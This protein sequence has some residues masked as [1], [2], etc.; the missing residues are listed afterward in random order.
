MHKYSSLF[1][2]T[3]TIIFIFH[4]FCLH[5]FFQ[6]A[7]PLLMEAFGPCLPNNRAG[8]DFIRFV[9]LHVEV[10]ALADADIQVVVDVGVVVVVD[11]DVDLPPLQLN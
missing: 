3:L 7:E 10:D 4:T 5:S 2:F 9:Y 8:G 1:S 11:I 6:K